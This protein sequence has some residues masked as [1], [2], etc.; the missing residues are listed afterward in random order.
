MLATLLFSQ[1]T[2][3][4]LAGDEF[5]Q[6]QSGN[7]N[8]YAQDN[9]TSWL[10]W[11][12]LDD[13]PDFLEQVRELV[14]LRRELPLLRIDDYVHGTLQQGSTAID[15]RWINKDG[16][17][18]HSDEW[19]DSHAFAVLLEQTCAVSQ[20]SAVAIFINRLGESITMDLPVTINAVDWHV[21]FSSDEQRD[22]VIQGRKVV[23]PG[24]S[25]TLLSS[26]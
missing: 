21:A 23:V 14:W 20:N 5:G 10:D 8:S 12:L 6:T 25:V 13:D 22:Q 2:P 3:M 1:G 16:Q 11:S 24:L 9:E 15:I 17:T 7:N 4:L 26:E 19:A 18:K